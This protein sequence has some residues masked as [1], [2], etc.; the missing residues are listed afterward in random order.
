[1]KMECTIMLSWFMMEMSYHKHPAWCPKNTRIIGE[2][3]FTCVWLKSFA[4]ACTTVVEWNLTGL[5]RANN[6][7][8]INV[9]RTIINEYDGLRW[10]LHSM[11]YRMTCRGK[12]AWESAG[13]SLEMHRLMEVSTPSWFSESA[14]IRPRRLLS[15]NG[16]SPRHFIIIGIELKVCF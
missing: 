15:M 4:F 1:M 6:E 7:D 9:P 14:S 2:C 12:L 16:Y 13:F 10:G 8:L 11:E 3:L 5:D